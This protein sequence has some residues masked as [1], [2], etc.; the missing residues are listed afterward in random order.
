MSNSFL[1]GNNSS[2]ST[3]VDLVNLVNVNGTNSFVG[4]QS[5][6]GFKL[7]SVA[8]GT[9]S[10][11]AI[12]KS[13]LDTKL[14]TTGGNL[15]GILSMNSSKIMSLA[16]G[17]ASLDAVNKSQLD[18]KLNINN[19]TTNLDMTNYSIT[20]VG[21]IQ[22]QNL[23]VSG[24]NTI[25]NSTNLSIADPLVNIGTGNT[26]GD[27]V[28]LGQIGT[29]NSSGVKY[30]SIFRDATDS[31]IKMLH[32]LT[33]APSGTVVDLTNGIKSD[34][35]IGNLDCSSFVLTGT[36]LTSTDLVKISGV[37]NGTASASKALVLDS[38]SNISSINDIT[39]SSV[40]VALVSSGADLTLNGGSNVI[41]TVAAVPVLSLNTN[42]LTVKPNTNMFLTHASNANSQ[43]FNIQQTGAYDS[44]IILSSSGTGNGIIL[45]SYSGTSYIYGATGVSLVAS[46]S[47]TT[48]I[49][50]LSNPYSTS[51]SSISLNSVSGGVS[52]GAGINV[53]LSAGGNINLTATQI[54]LLSP[55]LMNGIGTGINGMLAGT[56]STG[57]TISGITSMTKLINLTNS[58]TAGVLSVLAYTGTLLNKQEIR[59]YNGSSQNILLS[60]K[61][62]STNG[63]LRCKWA[64]LLPSSF[65]DVLF[66][67]SSLFFSCKD[68]LSD[69]L[70]WNI[71]KW[72]GDDVLKSYLNPLIGSYTTLINCNNSTS[73]INGVSSFSNWNGS[74]ATISNMTTSSY[75]GTV[76]T[77]NGYQAQNLTDTESNKFVGLVYGAT[78]YTMTFSSLSPGSY[79]QLCVYTLV[80]D[81][82]FARTLSLQDM[83][84]LKYITYNNELFAQSGSS[85][86]PGVILVY[87][88]F[89]SNGSTRVFN[90]SNGVNNHWYGLS[91]CNL[92]PYIL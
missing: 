38:S 78:S 29:Y 35:V 17:T 13:Q 85:N 76:S 37:T 72:T 5:V 1:N 70:Q 61:A 20:S 8:N 19:Q 12:N 77:Y 52:I 27:V 9:N 30:F 67:N 6:G 51:S 74:A 43:N 21:D 16:N 31:K 4:N 71:I 88:W 79:H 66:D 65:I 42:T 50:S 23:T 44:S 18:T 28:D 89:Q 64:N 2:S 82:G 33:V 48:G 34:L 39:A 62:S 25:M 91:V 57:C 14:D 26:S 45:N 49:I 46:S 41:L 53:L 86:V 3:N 32:G 15:T 83:D 63:N 59:I 24:T 54:N 11:D 75:V 81:T 56:I 7:T 10:G 58:N 36:T 92:G 80:Y 69:L 73:T 47:T 87:T 40:N 68:N 90:Y 84:T 60:Q 55:S 22:C